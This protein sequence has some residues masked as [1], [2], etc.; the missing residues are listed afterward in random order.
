MFSEQWLL[1]TTKQLVSTSNVQAGI[2]MHGVAVAECECP[3]TTPG[4]GLWSFC[5]DVELVDH[6][7]R[8][9]D[10]V[11]RR[12]WRCAARGGEVQKSYPDF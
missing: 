11:Q 6:M 2:S 3:V 12:I 10:R 7:N 9:S 5:P 1:R 8:C 4:R